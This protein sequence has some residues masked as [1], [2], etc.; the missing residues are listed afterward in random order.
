MH[1]K[2]LIILN[3]YFKVLSGRTTY[4]L[5]FSKQSTSLQFR[6][7]QAKEKAKKIQQG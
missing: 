1:L 7:L 5:F 4:V 6:Y 3:K 2:N